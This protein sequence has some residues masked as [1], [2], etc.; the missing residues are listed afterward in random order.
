MKRCLIVSLL[1]TISVRALA[2]DIPHGS[3]YDKRIQHVNYNSSDV[4]VINSLAGRGTRIVFSPDENILDIAS[5]FTRGWEMK[6]RRNILFLKPKSIPGENGQP[7]MVPKPVTWDTN[8]M[9]TTNLRLYDFDLRLAPETNSLNRKGEHAISYRVEFRYPKEQAEKDARILAKQA[10]LKRLDN[11]N[12]PKNMNYSMQIGDEAQAIA[13]TAAYDDGRFTYLKFPN[14]REFP[15]IFH[16]ADDKTE[17][18]VNYHIDPEIPDVMAVHRVAR[19][20]ALRLGNA[21]V[22]VYNES[23]DPN[24]IPA[25][26]GTTVPGVK[27]IIKAEEALNE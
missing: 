15:S 20:F 25:N 24:G 12:A 22:G 16:V 1:M 10:A 7:P 5:G 19:E 13:P 23:Y 14:N 2:L 6:D 11:K 26:E 17:S 4:V 21:V 27:R 18:I 8:L 9:V 3:H